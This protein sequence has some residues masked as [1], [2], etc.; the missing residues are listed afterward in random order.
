[1]N[2]VP[3]WSCEFKEAPSAP[4]LNALT[5]GAKFMLN[6]HGD[7]AVPWSKDQAVTPVFPAKEQAYSLTVLESQRLEPNDVQFVVTGYKAGKHEPEYVRFVQGD[8][9]FEFVK[10]KWEIQ[11]VLKQG[12]QPQPYAPFGPWNLNMPLWIIV[13]AAVILA[14]FAYLL[15]RFLRRRTQR[16]R[17][18]EELKLHRTALSPLHQFYRDSRQIRRKIH[19]AKNVEDLKKISEELDREFR[20]YVL[21]Q[22]EIPTLDW[23][24]GEILRDLK[25]RHRRVY[26]QASEPLKRILRELFRVRARDQLL[27][28]DVEQL[29]RMSLDAVERLESAQEVRR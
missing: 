25:K 6:C 23:S 29:H 15:V 11:S 7:L 5:V 17:M 24:D 1:M 8:K 10:P 2:E 21:R 4:S 22:F 14:L 18:L 28:P 3:V 9:G 20:L 13:C 16:R 19:N 27:L 12:E 26:R